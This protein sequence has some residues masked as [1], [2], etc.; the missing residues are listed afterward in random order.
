MPGGIGKEDRDHAEQVREELKEEGLGDV[1]PPR[2][3][4]AQAPS[5]DPQEPTGWFGRRTPPRNSEQ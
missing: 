4:D 1:I 2:G 5:G 3:Y